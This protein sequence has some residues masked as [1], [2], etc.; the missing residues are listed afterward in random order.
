MIEVYAYLKDKED[1]YHWSYACENAKE[2]AEAIE[3]AY[4]QAEYNEIDLD[5]FSI[6][7]NDRWL[8]IKA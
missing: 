3:V 8:E 4:Q 1:Y 5:T 7:M 2:V 6:V